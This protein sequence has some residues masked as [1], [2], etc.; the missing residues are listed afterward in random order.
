MIKSACSNALGDASPSVGGGSGDNNSNAYS[1]SRLTNDVYYNRTNVSLYPFHAN[2]I[3]TVLLSVSTR[4]S[5][6]AF[7]SP[8]SSALSLSPARM[9]VLYTRVKFRPVTK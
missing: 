6:C 3:R 5:R 7:T 1:A 8:I 2:G 4:S 9:V